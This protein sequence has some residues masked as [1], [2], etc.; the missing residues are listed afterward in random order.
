MQEIDR[1][2]TLLQRVRGELETLDRGIKGLELI[3]EELE[4]T[5]LD[6]LNNKVP[7]RWKFLYHSLMPLQNWMNDLIKRIEQLNDWIEKG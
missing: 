6:I 3:S 5:M 4:Q 7:A 2:N 1:F